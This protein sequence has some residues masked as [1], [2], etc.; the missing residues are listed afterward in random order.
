MVTALPDTSTICSVLVVCLGILL[1]IFSRMQNFSMWT[2]TLTSSPFPH[3]VGGKAVCLGYVA[4]HCGHIPKSKS[5]SSFNTAT[6]WRGYISSWELKNPQ[7]S[8]YFLAVE[9][10]GQPFLIHAVFRLWLMEV[11][12]L[13]IWKNSKGIDILVNK[14][15]NTWAQ[16]SSSTLIPLA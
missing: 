10:V 11:W 13:Y 6:F 16:P 2:D 8:V 4:V 7:I 12:S 5:S 14:S 1:F 15:E 9:L 3:G